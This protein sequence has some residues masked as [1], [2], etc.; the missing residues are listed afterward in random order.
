[1]A[2]DAGLMER[3]RT[4]GEAVLRVYAWAR[5]TLSF[6]RHENVLGRFDADSLARA[7]VGA[8]RRPTGGRVLL[9]DHEVTYSVTT[10]TRDDEPLSG[11][12]RGINTLLVA[13]LERLG[14]TVAEAGNGEALRPGGVACF[15]EPSTGELVIGDRKLVGSAQVRERGAL[16]QHGSILIADDQARITTL[17][18]A[19]VTPPLPAA[20][21]SASL[22]RAPSY[23]EVRDALFGALG[24]SVTAVEPLDTA[25]AAST[26][27]PFRARFADKEWTWRR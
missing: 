27:A 18:L 19:P 22:G 9:H 13:A 5:P 3:A 21:L 20:T 24:T 15:A 4:T 26:A 2:L 7:G 6:G 1:M 16:L 25:A 8:V 10:P 12:Y 23:E 11:S 14:V 17:A